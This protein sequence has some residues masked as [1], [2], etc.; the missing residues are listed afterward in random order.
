MEHGSSNKTLTSLEKLSFW[1]K[2]QR[3]TAQHQFF[4]G[5]VFDFSWKENP[6][7]Y[8]LHF[9]QTLKFFIEK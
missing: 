8:F 2:I 3:F 9:I 7:E 1:L 4:L 6:K 5:Y